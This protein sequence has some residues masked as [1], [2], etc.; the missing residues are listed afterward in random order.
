MA[1]DKIQAE[2]MNLADTYAFTG[3][4]TGAGTNGRMNLLATTTVSSAVADVTFGSSYITSTYRAYFLEVFDTQPSSDNVQPF[5]AIS[6]DNFSS[7]DLDMINRGTRDLGNDSST[8]SAA[9]GD[10]YQTSAEGIRLASGGAYS[11]GNRNV[12]LKYQLWNPSDTSCRTSWDWEIIFWNYDGYAGKTHGA[13]VT[14]ATT[15]VNGIRFLYNSG[16][17]AKGTFKLYGVTT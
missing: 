5:M 2:S 17:I 13:G 3:T 4:V 11:A 14:N 6:T 16:N 10:V 1:I 8:A 12:S 9:F 7:R 15:A